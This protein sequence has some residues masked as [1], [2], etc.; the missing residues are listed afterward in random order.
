MLR[1]KWFG[2]FL[3][4]IFWSSGAFAAEGCTVNRVVG[5]V[6]VIRDGQSMPA[7]EN[8]QLKKGDR[9][10]TGGNCAADMSM[11]GL[12]GCRVLAQSQVEVAGWKKENMSLT[13]S[14]GNVILNLEKL[15]T[16]STF[17]VET[18]T[19]VAAVRGTQFWGRVE[20]ASP[21]NP[22]TTFAVRSGVV[23][24][25]DKVSSKT[26]ELQKGQ[27]L[28]ISK[29]AAVAPSV[30]TA[31]PEEMQAMEQADLISTG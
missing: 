11:N 6:R 7:K 23:Q 20:N 30:R 5:D 24:I 25:T 10:E 4:G 12:A 16:D 2:I 22:V 28:D 26:F 31:L 17:R 21:E 27:A 1:K 15:P 19:A 14:K 18:P 8:D 3:C 9:L 29:T 13:V